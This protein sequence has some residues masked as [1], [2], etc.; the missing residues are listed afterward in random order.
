MDEDTDDICLGLEQCITRDGQKVKPIADMDWN[1]QKIINI[2]EG[3]KA[4]DA[5]TLK[6]LQIG[7]NL[8]FEAARKFYDN[9]DLNICEISLP[10]EIALAAEDAGMR[11]FIKFYAFNSLEKINTYTIQQIINHTL[12]L[13]QMEFLLYL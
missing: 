8:L 2:A 1:N 3:E 9:P 4:N 6:Q 5:I 10:K 11:I 12:S 7:G 13:M